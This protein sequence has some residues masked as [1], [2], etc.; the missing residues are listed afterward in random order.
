MKY[1]NDEITKI[2]GINEINISDINNNIILICITNS[3]NK[4]FMRSK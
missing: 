3:E 1:W 2:S 4:N